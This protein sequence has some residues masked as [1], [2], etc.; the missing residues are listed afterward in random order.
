LSTAAVSA[1]RG[2]RGGRPLTGN[3][4]HDR[5]ACPSPRAE[6]GNATGE[7]DACDIATGPAP[8]CNGNG[9]PDSCDIAS[10][11]A[12]DC[13]GNG[14]PDSCDLASGQGQD[15]NGNGTPDVIVGAGV[16]GRG[17]GVLVRWLRGNP[18]RPLPGPPFGYTYAGYAWE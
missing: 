1:S 13:N 14:K 2:A 4:A 3:G 9:K 8:D 12:Q 11:Q 5:A 16:G 15:C 6:D 17:V 18:G 10:G 7:P